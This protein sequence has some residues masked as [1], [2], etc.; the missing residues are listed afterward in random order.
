MSGG[1]A[2]VP[3]GYARVAVHGVTAVA[4]VPCAAAVRAAL[5]RGTLYDYAR[6]HPARVELA[7]RAPAY[8]VPLPR[9]GTRVVVRHG[10]HGGLLAPVTGDRFLPPT[11][12]P[13]ELRTSLRLA[14]AGVPTP[15]VVAYAVYDA[16]LGMRTSD[17]LT[18]EVPDAL[19]LGAALAAAR[20]DEAKS[21][22]L[23]ATGVLLD[24]LADA[25]ARHPDL[26]IKN[27][28]LTPTASPLGFTAHVLDIDRVV[29]GSDRERVAEANLARLERSIAKWR[30][31]GRIDVSDR[32]LT[33][34]R[35]AR[36]RFNAG[37]R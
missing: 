25:E 32:A 11:R 10:W 34:L 15:Q 22:L 27:V 5:R 14:E 3:E 23:A 7:G 28:L 36:P 2:A 8:A 9:T 35:T 37:A 1:G 21:A 12:A 26:N 24:A 29:M 19:D 4:L 17:V 20:D 18:R 31:A 6:A 13:H 33:A 30:A 16:P